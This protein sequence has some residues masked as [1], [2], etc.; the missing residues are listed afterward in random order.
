MRQEKPFIEIRS[1]KSFK[2]R[3]IKIKIGLTRSWMSLDI[4]LL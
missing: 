4:D 1:V 3:D 2:M